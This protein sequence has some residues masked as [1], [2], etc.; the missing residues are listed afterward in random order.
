M[1]PIP[2]K[3]ICAVAGFKEA[4]AARLIR[5][6]GLKGVRLD[7]RNMCNE[8][9]FKSDDTLT[10]LVLEWLQHTLST[11]AYVFDF[12]LAGLVR[13]GGFK[14]PNALDSMSCCRKVYYYLLRPSPYATFAIPYRDPI[15]ADKLVS[16]RY[17]LV[18]AARTVLQT[19]L[20]LG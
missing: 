3:P 4:V 15:F 1:S 16:A 13:S 11:C 14:F 10:F 2:M 20:K 7:S 9:P 5:R 8:R 12:S 17:V 19:G 18:L 6:D